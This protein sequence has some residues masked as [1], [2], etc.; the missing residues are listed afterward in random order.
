MSCSISQSYPGGK[1]IPQKPPSPP[2]LAG[3][4]VAR[5]VR[6]AVT[7]PLQAKLQAP[8]LPGRQPAAHVQAA[9]AA[10]QPKKAPAPAPGLRAVQAKLPVVPPQRPGTDPRHAVIQKASYAAEVLDEAKSSGARLDSKAGEWI[11]LDT[12]KRSYFSWFSQRIRER[13]GIAPRPANG[14]ICPMCNKAGTN[15]ELDHM[16]PWRHYI[17]ALV[18]SGSVKK[19]GGTL[20]VRGDIARALYNDPENLWWICRDCN[21]PKSDI[22][23][24][25]AAHVSGDFSAGTYGRSSDYKPSAIVAENL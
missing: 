5:H 20:M 14:S 3:R 6:D 13:L 10:A 18:G 2:P 19:M 16:T 4:P 8:P 12:V 21:N 11:D 1:A 9:L 25:T 22:I 15:F 23:P 7:R 17:A 24:E